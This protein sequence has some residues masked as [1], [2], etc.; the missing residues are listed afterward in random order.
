MALFVRSMIAGRGSHYS[1][2]I[3]IVIACTG[4]NWLLSPWLTP[5]DAAMVYLLGIIIASV[6]YDRPV[7]VVAALLSFLAFD[8]FF[9]P[10]TLTLRFGT[11]Q[12]LI[13]AVV[14]LIAGFVTS[15]L[16]SRVRREMKSASQAAVV[17]NEERIRNSLLASL[18]HDLRTPLA[19][20]AG[21][22]S[23]LR[24]NRS[25]L[26]VEEQDQL[27]ETIFQRSVRMSTEVTDL[28]EMTQLHAGRVSLDRQ[29]YPIEELIGA[30]LERCR[31]LTHGHAVTVEM[32]TDMYLVHVDGVLIEKL[33]VNLIENAALHTPIGT[34]IHIAA[35][36]SD[37]A[38]IVSVSDDGPGLRP[39]SEELLF[40]KFERGTQSGTSSG[41][42]LGLSICRAISELHGL[43]ITARNRPE[44]GAEFAVRF[45]ADPMAPMQVGS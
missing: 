7:S 41:S 42:G 29:W 6:Y 27:L 15:A 16:A 24:E 28:L 4:L 39:G 13:T 9:V 20:I 3:L 38:F 45:P 21:S 33:F 17:A 44:G 23:S 26:S 5:T 10:P 1:V 22:A 25:R 11:A 35:A 36:R 8:F 32:P 31:S 40:E 34:A 30:A 19:V 14:L 37:D 2:T 18:S 43:A 12:Y